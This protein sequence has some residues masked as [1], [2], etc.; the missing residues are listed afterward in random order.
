MTNIEFIEKTIAENIGGV[1]VV[2][3][4]PVL[5]LEKAENML[6]EMEAN[7]GRLFKLNAA[8]EDL[9]ELEKNSGVKII[10][11]SC[12]SSAISIVERKYTLMNFIY[13]ETYR[14]LARTKLRVI[15]SQTEDIQKVIN[16]EWFKLSNS[17]KACFVSDA[18][19][20]LQKEEIEKM[21]KHIQFLVSDYNKVITRK[22]DK[23]PLF[24]IEYEEN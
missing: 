24:A 9:S 15:C 16:N 13:N 14:D 5:S 6:S 20:I 8:F 18:I 11:V 23:K 1:N 12:F 4:S 19:F 17:T 2:N 10:S 22:R 3:F 21:E 7:K